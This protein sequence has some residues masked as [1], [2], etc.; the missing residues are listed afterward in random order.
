[1][2]RLNTLFTKSLLTATYDFHKLNVGSIPLSGEGYGEPWVI[3]SLPLQPALAL[4]GLVFTGAH[5]PPKVADERPTTYIVELHC[6]DHI[7]QEENTFVVHWAVL[8]TCQYSSYSPLHCKGYFP[9]ALYS[10][11]LCC[12]QPYMRSWTLLRSLWLLMSSSCIHEP[13]TKP[14]FNG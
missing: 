6:C 1:M 5:K 14:K 4:D 12:Q 3:S 10:H 9:L 7:R 11:R 2:W 8:Y 13:L